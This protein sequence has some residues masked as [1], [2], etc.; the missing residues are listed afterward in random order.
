MSRRESMRSGDVMTDAQKVKSERARM[1]DAADDPAQYT[2]TRFGRKPR[3]GTWGVIVTLAILAWMR[4]VRGLR[5][6]LGWDSA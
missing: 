2:V 6:A 3:R 1:T 4:V 5:R